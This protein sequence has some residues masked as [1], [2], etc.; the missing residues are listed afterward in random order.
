MG[1]RRCLLTNGRESSTRGWAGD[2][3]R[4]WAVRLHAGPVTERE[5]GLVPARNIGTKPAD[6]I[7]TKQIKLYKP[8]DKYRNHSR[9]AQ[10]N[11]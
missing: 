9:I 6:G 7:L 10:V 8:L 11:S 1:T 2:G 3:A 4:A 5:N